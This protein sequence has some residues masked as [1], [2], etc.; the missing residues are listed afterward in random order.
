[1]LSL[2]M[3]KLYRKAYSSYPNVVRTILRRSFMY[4]KTMNYLDVLERKGEVFVIRPHVKPVSRLE[5]NRE[6]LYAFYEHGYHYMERQL[7]ALEEYLEK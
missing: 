1:M 2:A 6:A 5:R 4:N 7:E 3:Q